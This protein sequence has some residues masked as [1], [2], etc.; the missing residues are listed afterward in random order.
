MGYFF[1]AYETTRSKVKDT[2][3]CP[4]VPGQYLICTDSGDVFYD[5]EDGA[6]KH[7]TDIID[8]ET[9]AERIAILAPLDKIHFVKETAH[10]WRYLNGVWVDLSTVAF[11]TKVKPYIRT[12]DATEWSNGT[13]TI[14]LSEHNQELDGGVVL[15]KVYMLSDSVYSERC[16]AAMDT[17][18]SVS[19]DKS[20]VLSYD[21]PAY[22]GK[23]ILIG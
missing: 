21:G 4:I 13:F 3:L 16:L 22:S 17:E 23:V 1:S 11:S 7:L 20:I 10:F 14:P 19:Y 2:S 18:V 8:L 12:F 6:R 9:D 15:S 5:T